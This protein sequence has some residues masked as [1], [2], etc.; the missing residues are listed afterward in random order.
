MAFLA[1]AALP[2]TVDGPQRTTTFWAVTID[3]SLLLLF[4]VQHSVMARRTVKAR[5]RRLVPVELERTIYVLATNLCL[6]LL[7]ALWQP[8]H[9]QIWHVEGP[10][11]P[12]SGRS[13]RPA[14]SSRSR[15]PSPST[16]SSSSGF[17]RPAG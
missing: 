17:A 10:P 11:P 15:R 12:S 7:L 13:A 3:V 6:A 9:E 2:R 16:T 1:G 8:W 4:A 14:G 5:L